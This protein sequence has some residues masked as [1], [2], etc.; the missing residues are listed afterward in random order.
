MEFQSAL[1]Q[2]ELLEIFNV[3]IVT[4]AQNPSRGEA[5]RQQLKIWKS[6]LSS[7]LSFLANQHEGQPQ[8]FLEFP[9]T[10][11]ETPEVTKSDSIRLNFSA[12]AQ[13]QQH[14]KSTGRTFSIPI[15][16]DTTS[17]VRRTCMFE[18]ILWKQAC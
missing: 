13:R 17:T 6:P 4:S 1:R 18:P 8:P 11:F 2:R 14:R 12:V 7:T 9:I 5:T 10:A 16:T 15:R 3:K